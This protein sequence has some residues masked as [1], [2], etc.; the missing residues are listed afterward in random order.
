MMRKTGAIE[1][2]RYRQEEKTVLVLYRLH[3]LPLHVKFQNNAHNR[4]CY[5]WL[6]AVARTD[7][8]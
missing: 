8:S 4:K 6:G 5:I 2:M 3:E 7:I 1:T